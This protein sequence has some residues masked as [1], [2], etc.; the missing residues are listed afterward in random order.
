MGAQ[1]TNDQLA[2]Q[3]VQMDGLLR[4]PEMGILSS[5]E[6]TNRNFLWLIHRLYLLQLLQHVQLEMFALVF[7]NGHQ[8]Q[9]GII[10]ARKTC[11]LVL[12]DR[13][14]TFVCS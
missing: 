8:H 14:T 11:F 6:A 9:S 2:P 7:R 5:L 10:C 13:K 1:T 4:A 12:S 3:P